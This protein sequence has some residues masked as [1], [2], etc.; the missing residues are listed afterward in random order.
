ME[1]E[2]SGCV[3]R[4]QRKE[5]NISVEILESDAKPLSSRVFFTFSRAQHCSEL[6]GIPRW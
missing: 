5:A 6:R 3:E 2:G 4:D 1:V